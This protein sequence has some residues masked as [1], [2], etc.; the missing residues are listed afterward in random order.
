MAMTASP[1]DNYQPAD[2]YAPAPNS[3]LDRNLFLVK[4][5]VGAFRASSNY[6]ILDPE[7]GDIILRCG[8]PNLGWITKIFRFTKYKRNT[9]FHLC[10]TTPEGETVVQVQRGISLFRSDV[11]VHDGEG[12]RL[13]R[14]RQKWFSIGGSFSVLGG[15]DQPICELKG[16][17][18]GWNFRFL[19][20]TTELASVTKKW[21]GIGKELF[22]S[23]DNY[24]LT[25]DESIPAG[26]P[27]RKL[28]LAAVLSIDLVLKE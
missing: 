23:A 26:H 5:H 7:T 3:A 19:S 4:E 12:E 2:F 9:P 8:E 13:G 24:I 1:P 6:D 10:V 11:D 15:Q 14:F 25:I 20:G 18:T 28:I 16:K 22:T 21:S 17:W 27:I